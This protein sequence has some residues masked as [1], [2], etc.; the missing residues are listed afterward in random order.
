MPSF[1]NNTLSSA[2]MQK[3]K[4]LVMSA[5]RENSKKTPLFLTFT[6]PLNP[7]IKISPMTLYSKDTLYR[8]LPSCKPISETFYKHFSKMSK[9]YF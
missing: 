1:T 4:K 2:I 8:L 7:Q 9:N 3:I 5:F 6:P